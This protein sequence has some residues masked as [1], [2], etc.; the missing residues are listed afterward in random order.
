M[1]TALSL[2]ATTVLLAVAAPA[3]AQKPAG[4]ANVALARNDRV[5]ST[6]NLADLRAIVVAEGH[7]IDEERAVTDVSIRGRTDAGLL[8]LLIGTACNNSPNCAGIMMQIRYDSD[9]RVTLE[10]VNRANVESAS[11]ATWWDIEARTVGFTRYVVLDHGISMA[12]IREN[13][14]VL[15]DV[16]AT[17]RD[18]VF[19]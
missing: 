19:P 15:F 16:H 6:V 11:V 8:F 14:R 12:N 4:T 18:I 7:N 9:E 13:L 3:L 2:F 10:R 5:V 1:R 17:P